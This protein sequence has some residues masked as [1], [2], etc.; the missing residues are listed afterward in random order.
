[1]TIG[2]RVSGLMLFAPFL[3]SASIPPRIKIILVILFT[4]VL[5]PVQASRL[6]AVSV[7]NWPLVVASELLLGIGFGI[8]SSLVFD[9]AQ[10]AGQVLSVQVGYSLVNILDPQTQVESTVMALF[11]QT[12]ALLIFLR[13]D[14]HYWILRALANSFSYLPPGT[15][16]LNQAFVSALFRVA[17]G[18][19]EVGIQIA[20]PVLSATLVADV[21]LGLLGK[22]SPQ[23]GVMLLG[24][25]VKSMLGLTLLVAVLRYWPPLFE[26]LFVQSTSFMERLLQLAR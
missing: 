18:V 26:R 23:L 14:V 22:A 6:G 9:A 7:T 2:L 21:V 4:A 11:H 10:L 17:G 24:P 13:L 15:A 5:Y 3:G 20:A 8:A 25:A 12:I 16:N 1:M 19:F